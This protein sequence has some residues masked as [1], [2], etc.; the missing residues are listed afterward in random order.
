[1]R[2]LHFFKSYAPDSF[3]GTQTVIGDIA[4][5]TAPFGIETEVLSLSRDPERNSVTIEGH[6]AR[7]AKLDFEIASTGFS[8]SALSIF[9]EMAER[10]DVV[11]YHYPWPLMDAVHFLSRVKK[12][13]VVTYHSDI[14]RQRLL[15]TVYRPLMRRFL[16]SVTAVV[17]TSPN[18]V[19]SSPILKDYAHK[20]SVIPLGA[21]DITRTPLAPDAVAAW[22]KRLGERF[23]VF[24]G[25]LRYYKG[26]KFLLDAAERTGL[27]V[28]IIGTGEQAGELSAEIARRKLTNVHLLGELTERDKAVVLKLAYGFLFP[29]HLRSEAFGVALLEAAAS[30]LP[31]VCCELGTGTSYVNQHGVTGLV[32][33]P[34]DPEALAEA[35]E[36]LWADPVGAAAMGVAARRRYQDLF[37]AD[38]MGAAYAGLYRDLAAAPRYRARTPAAFYPLSQ[39]PA[40]RI[41]S[42]SIRR[43]ET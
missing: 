6:L 22:K 32:I 42:P 37:T 13:T 40:A 7:K 35:M 19:A 28:A 27:P 8:L 3:G 36:T 10:A 2:V 14:V 12:P 20:L 38:E 16:D 39:H 15:K 30:S 26:L 11:H 4:H 18:Y 9:T 5:G 34:A 21:R 1:M 24:V 25:A 41:T 17:A 33:P 43:S 29:S 31:M 23:F